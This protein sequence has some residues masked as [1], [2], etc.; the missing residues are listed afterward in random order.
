VDV[1]IGLRVVGKAAC[2][3]M[4][5]GIC[6]FS[7][8][9]AD[10]AST[11]A[12]SVVHMALEKSDSKRFCAYEISAPTAAEATAISHYWT[13]LARSAVRTVSEG[14]MA[15]TVPKAHLTQAQRRA[16]RLAERAER[17]LAPKPRLVCV[18]IPAG[19]PR[20]PASAGM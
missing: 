3:V 2:A 14:K 19:R 7:A 10:A 1:V 5:C 4:L 9:C 11:A 15:V 13:R 12:H 20:S 6:V 18:Q 8:G 16:L 17:A